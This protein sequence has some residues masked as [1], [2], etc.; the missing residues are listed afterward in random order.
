MRLFLLTALTM[1]AFAANSVLNRMAVGPGLIGPVEF[2]VI[3]L[4]G[5]AA[6]LALLLVWRRRARQAPIWPGLAGR[7]PGVA[8]LLVYL[9]GFRW[10]IAGWMRA[11]ARWSCSAR[12]RSP[13]SPGR[14]WRPRPCRR[15]AGPAPGWRWRG[16][17]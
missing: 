5:G 14:C 13:C 8:G 11:P 16:W 3:R 10:P 2:A 12:C 17:R 7:G 15:A 9:F 1:L 6:M 4:L